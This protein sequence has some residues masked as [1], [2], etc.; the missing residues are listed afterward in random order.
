MFESNEVDNAFGT[1]S[2]SPRPTPSIFPRATSGSS[3]SESVS[4]RNY[5]VSITCFLILAYELYII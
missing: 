1:R 4:R 2:K 3:N 5:Y